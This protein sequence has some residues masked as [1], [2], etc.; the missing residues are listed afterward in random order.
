MSGGGA[1][2][3]ASAGSIVA[4]STAGQAAVWAGGAAVVPCGDGFGV[5]A[6]GGTLPG[7]GV[8]FGIGVC[9]GG[10]ADCAPAVTPSITAATIINPGIHANPRPAFRS[11][12]IL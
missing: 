2:Y 12:S 7:N 4:A 1:A 5:V 9:A 6:G 8:G 11:T 3:T 10:G